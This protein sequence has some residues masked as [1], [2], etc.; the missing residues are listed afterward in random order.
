MARNSDQDH[1]RD[2]L[3]EPRHGA[4]PRR[5]TDRFGRLSDGFVHGFGSA[6][7]LVAQTLFV[8]VWVGFNVAGAALRWDAYPFVFLNLVFSTQ[9]AYAGPLIL[10]TQNRQDVQDKAVLERDRTTAAYAMAETEFLAREMADLRN[11]LDRKLDRQDMTDPVATL[12]HAIEG[13]TGR[14]LGLED[15]E[16]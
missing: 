15:D 9:A 12:A 6:R 16:D 5:H 1:H 10:L 14:S 4:T 11:I 8:I 13:F 7:F 3:D 2:H